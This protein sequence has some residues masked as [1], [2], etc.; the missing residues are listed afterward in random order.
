MH[1]KHALQTKPRLTGQGEANS[2]ACTHTAS[3]PLQQ[4]SLVVLD[5]VGAFLGLGEVDC[6]A[7][8]WALVTAAILTGLHWW[9]RRR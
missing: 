7:A 9:R 4:N 6:L 1:L 3:G 8:A 2:A 5:V